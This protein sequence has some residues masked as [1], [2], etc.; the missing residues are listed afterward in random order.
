MNP[1]KNIAP[2]SIKITPI[3]VMLLPSINHTSG[4]SMTNATPT[5]IVIN[6]IIP[7]ITSSQYVIKHAKLHNIHLQ[8]I[9]SYLPQ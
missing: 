7:K 8:L 3:K 6:T 5:P 9:S 4:F 2:V 1:G